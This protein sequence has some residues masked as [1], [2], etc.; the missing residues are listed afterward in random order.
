MPKES[1][2]KSYLSQVITWLESFPRAEI[3]TGMTHPLLMDKSNS[4]FRTDLR[5]SM[6]NLAH[7]N[8]K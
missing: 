5:D 6:Y 2:S 1:S 8:Y 7:L 4:D 3:A